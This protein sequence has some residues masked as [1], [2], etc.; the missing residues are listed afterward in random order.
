M[1]FKVLILKGV[2]R[3]QAHVPENGLRSLYN[4]SFVLE[5]SQI[6]RLL[7]CVSAE[8][9]GTPTVSRG[10]PGHGGEDLC[11]DLQKCKDSIN[12]CKNQQ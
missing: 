5:F 6:C 3:P 12:R 10:M 7:S 1:V 4:S 9:H 8:G 11:S 2:P